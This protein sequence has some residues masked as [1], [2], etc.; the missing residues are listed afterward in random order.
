MLGVTSTQKR[1]RLRL[2]R[3][4]DRKRKGLPLRGVSRRARD[5]G[6]EAEGRDLDTPNPDLIG[7]TEDL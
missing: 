1:D 5:P 4:R 2:I 7:F 6:D 3:R